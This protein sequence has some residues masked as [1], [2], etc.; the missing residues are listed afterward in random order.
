MVLGYVKTDQDDHKDKNAY[1]CAWCG[2]FITHTGA[3]VKIN[4]ADSHSFVNPSGVRCNFRTFQDCENVIIHEELYMEHS[5]FAGYGWRF[6]MCGKCFHHLGWKYD[7]VKKR[8]AVKEFFGVLDD[9]VEP[10]PA[11][12]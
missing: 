12:D 3:L 5:W 10:V 4:G 6:L 11:G 9:A 2:V 8:I 1:H 7:A